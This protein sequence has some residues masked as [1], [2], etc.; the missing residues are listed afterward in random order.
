[1]SD[2]ALA[3]LVSSRICHDLVNPIGAIGNGL[4][5]LELT[6]GGSEEMALI[7]QAYENAN[8]RINFFRIAFGAAAPGQ[9]AAGRTLGPMLKTLS[10]GGRVSYN[11]DP[12]SEL[13]RQEAKVLMLAILCLECALPLGGIISVTGPRGIVA[14]SDRLRADPEL[15]CRAEAPGPINDLPA[16]Q[17]QFALLP[18]AVEDIGGALCIEHSPSEIRI[19]F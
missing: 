7:K 2:K 12:P 4:E 19:S 10:Q 11:W 5:L 14:S 3:M 15:W 9:S 8:A 6:G 18:I 16:A 1:M 17:V 13:P